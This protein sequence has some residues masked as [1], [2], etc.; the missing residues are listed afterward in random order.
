[1]S[2]TANMMLRG[3]SVFPGAF[4]GS[5]L[6]AVGVWNFVSSI[7]PWPS[8]V[9]IIAMS[10][11]VEP[12]DTVH[13]TSLD[14]RLAL[15]LHTKFDKERNSSL[16]VVDDDAHVVHP[17]NRHSGSPSSSRGPSWPRVYLG[18][19]QRHILDTRKRAEF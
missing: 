17:L 19:S 7:Q 11:P 8:G 15:K 10:T 1:M 14:Q 5:A 2:S 3:P 9:S 16:K 6:T 18:R 4:S 13:P 12:D